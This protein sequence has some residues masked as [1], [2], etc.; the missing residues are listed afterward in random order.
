[1]QLHVASVS[2]LQVNQILHNWGRSR[3]QQRPAETEWG[4][5]LSDIKFWSVSSDSGS[6]QFSEEVFSQF[7]SVKG[8]IPQSEVTWSISCLLNVYLLSQLRA[9]CCSMRA[10]MVTGLRPLVICTGNPE[11]QQVCPSIRTTEKHLTLTVHLHHVSN[12]AFILKASAPLNV[13]SFVLNLLLTPAGLRT[14][15]TCWDCYLYSHQRLYYSCDR[16]TQVI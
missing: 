9:Q 16:A 12:Y 5:Q 10:Q 6:V 8:E 14:V 1:M 13:S 3:V 4:V 2:F 11:R 7:T 15:H